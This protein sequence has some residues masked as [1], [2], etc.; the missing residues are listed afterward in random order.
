LEERKSKLDVLHVHLSEG[1]TQAK[2]KEFIQTAAD[3]LLS[4][5]KS[6]RDDR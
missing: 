2:D 5:F 1:A 4:S 6:A 3:E